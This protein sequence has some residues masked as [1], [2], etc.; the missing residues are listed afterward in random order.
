MMKPVDGYEELLAR[1]NENIT[2]LKPLI[3]FA[4]AV[5]Q[6][7]QDSDPKRSAFVGYN[8]S[9]IELYLRIGPEDRVKDAVSLVAT[10]CR[11]HGIAEP[12]QWANG[13]WSVFFPA[14]KRSLKLIVM[15][16]WAAGG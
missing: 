13:D 4:Q 1:E 16:T 8:D 12:E 6:E 9:R 2:R 3:E 14:D 7:W 15:H 11:E 5:G 10:R